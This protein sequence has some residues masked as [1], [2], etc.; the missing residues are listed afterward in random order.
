M[1]EPRP[2]TAEKSA[3]RLAPQAVVDFLE[4]LHR[5]FKIGTYYPEGHAVLDRAAQLFQHHLQK[6]A[7]TSKTAAIELRA[8][9]IVVGDQEIAA[10]TPAL[11]EIARLLADLGINRLEIDRAVPLKDLLQLIRTLLL[12]RAQL[13][14]VKQFTQAKIDGLPATI[15]VLQQEFLIDQSTIIATKNHEQADQNL[16]TVLQALETQGLDRQQIARCRKFLEELSRRFAAQPIKVQ[17]LPAIGWHDVSKLLTRALS[18]GIDFGGDAVGMG[19]RNDLNALT[20]IFDG[21]QQEV[22]DRDSRESINLLVSIFARGHLAARPKPGSERGAGK[23]LH[24]RD[25][26]T[27]MT[28]GEIQA[29]VGKNLARQEAP[30]TIKQD[31]R[32]HELSILLQ[33]LQ[34][35]L[36]AA[37][38]EGIRRNLRDILATAPSPRMIEVLIKGLTALT[39]NASDLE[40]VETVRFIAGQLRASETFSSLSF[41]VLLCRALPPQHI[42]LLWTTLVGELLA[43]GRSSEQRQLF[44]VLARIAATVPAQAMNDQTAR[45]E[46]LEAIKN[47]KIASDIFNPQLTAAY[48]LYGALLGTSLRTAVATRLLAAFKSQ[49]PEWFIGALAPL[50]DPLQQKHLHLLTAYLHMA[51]Q[52]HLPLSLLV[53]AGKLVVERLPLLEEAAREEAWVARTIEATP[54][55]QVEGTRELL[56]KILAEKRLMVVPKWPSA[57]RQAATQALQKLKRKPLG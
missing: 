5:L 33:L 43:V 45:L 47:K 56:E 10:K 41:L 54:Q 34:F 21:L 51:R 18:S 11:A 38:A 20:T 6:V 27:D 8:A 50:L 28:I 30:P 31:D 2:A 15:R 22:D 37:T 44:E 32:R 25:R 9:S 19:W 3:P 52:S 29:F 55:M 39:Q 14:G 57:C 49:P 23:S 17:G 4:A 35:P 12:H 40:I 13:Q 1:S 36:E 24:A 16:D 7:Q 26:N 48:P 53:M 42:E 46:E